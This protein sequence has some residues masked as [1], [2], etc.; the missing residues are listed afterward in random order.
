MWPIDQNLSKIKLVPY[1]LLFILTIIMPTAFGQSD[2]LASV[3]KN[4]QDSLAGQNNTKSSSSEQ[5]TKL[6]SIPVGSDIFVRTK[7][8]YNEDRIIPTWEIPSNT[9][10]HFSKGNKL[11]PQNNCFQELQEGDLDIQGNES[12]GIYGTLKIEDPLTSTVEFKNYKIYHA[13]GWAIQ[14]TKLQQDTKYKQTNYFFDGLFGFGKYEGPTNQEVQ[15]HIRGTFQ[16]P[17]GKLEF[18]GKYTTTDEF[19]S[20]KRK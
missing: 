12:M 8:T 7:L 13:L 5:V 18:T 14:I 15:Y 16:E 17:S 10:I 11:C 19:Y 2:D 1:A 4:A 3:L 6:P 20:Q 9:T